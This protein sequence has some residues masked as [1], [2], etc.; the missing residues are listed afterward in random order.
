MSQHSLFHLRPQLGVV[1][2]RRLLLHLQLVAR[3]AVLLLGPPVAAGVVRQAVLPPEPQHLHEE[4]KPAQ[5]RQFP[6]AVVAVLRQLLLR[7]LLPLV[8]VAALRL[9]W[10]S[11][12]KNLAMVSTGLPRALIVTIR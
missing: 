7:R 6:A 10:L 4:L 11:L 2:A 12:P 3:A 1:A 8:A 9:P 5:F